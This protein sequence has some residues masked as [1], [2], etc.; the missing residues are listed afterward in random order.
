M[1]YQFQS[2]QGQFS[3]K[4]KV[5]TEAIK[6]LIGVNVILFIIDSIFLPLNLSGVFGLSPKTVWPMFWQPFSYMFMHGGVWHIAIN[7]LVLWMF[8]S[9][10]ETIWGRTK[11]IKYYF[12]T[13]VG[14]GLVW[15]V[16]NISNSYMILIGASGAVY[17]IL[18]AYGM[19]FPNRTVL[20]YFVI[21]IKVKWF[22]LIIGAIAFYSSWGT[23]SNISHL[24]HLSGMLI[25]YIYLTSNNRWNKT[26]FS[27]RK[28]FIDLRH[29]FEEK[30]HKKTAETEKTVSKILDRVRKEGYEKLTKEEE[31][32]LYS[33][34]KNL[35]KKKEKN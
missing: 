27:L 6:I 4:P 25:G 2:Q 10:L 12:V 31:D 1:R 23:H 14:S 5:F 16:F 18:L 33:A 29:H 9:E 21:P 22:V 19:M 8:G 26:S 17:G 13:G 15:L 34:S 20:L 35:S 30:K 28:I 11:F 3:W 24:T 32:L 7:M